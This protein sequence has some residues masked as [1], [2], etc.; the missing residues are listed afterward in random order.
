[1]A[2]AVAVAAALVVALLAVSGAGGADV[3]SP[4]RGDT[5]V[6]G[7]MREPPCINAYLLRCGDNLD[8]KNIMGLALRGAFAI[9]PG[10]SWRPGLVTRADFTTKP[11]FTITYHIRPEARW[12]D[13][14]PITASD[15]VFTHEVRR[16]VAERLINWEK[17]HLNVIRSV[18]A[19]DAKTVEVVLRAKFALWRRLFPYVLPRHALR[20]E[21]FSTVWLDRIHN[22]KT[23]APIG[24]GPFLFG[25]WERGRGLTF[26]RNPRYWGPHVAHLDG[27]ALRFCRACGEIVREQIEWLRAREL[28]LAVN[29]PF[30][31]QQVQEARRLPGVRV[32]AAPGP[33][34]EH[35]EIR[36]GPGG[37]PALERKQIR[38]A[39]AYGIDRVAIARA[40]Y[41]STDARYPLS[42][43][44]VF[45]SGSARYRPN[46]RTYR[47]RPAEARRLLEREGCRSGSDGIFVC[48][49]E[50][51]SLRFVTTVGD[52]RV[53]TLEL[54][55]GHL[56]QAGIEV[57]P[58]YGT[59]SVVLSQIL[60]AA[61]AGRGDFD[62]ILF[63]F[64]KEPLTPRPSQR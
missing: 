27:V 2:R 16:S 11:P 22:P 12:S 3:Q 15:F 49:G 4:K 54:V 44:A 21:D 32:L 46:W 25:R 1:M 33:A 31:G 60:P 53:R 36:I 14:V 5:V 10:F 35:F 29:T 6:V 64:T 62:L 20:G 61:L 42:D 38:R 57:R 8:P 19:V 43:S 28:D 23:G 24:S 50:R 59:P 63:A 34:W 40:L 9:G 30:S 7:T 48:A 55:Q 56:R 45:P 39:I 37:H 17:E 13:G 47:Y 26:V 41:G 51:M 52:V 58:V 18:R